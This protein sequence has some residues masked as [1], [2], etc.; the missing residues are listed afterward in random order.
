MIFPAPKE[1]FQLPLRERGGSRGLGMMGDRGLAT[2]LK[3]T[4]KG[5]EMVQMVKMTICPMLT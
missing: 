5:I 1:N 3:E 2:G 4:I